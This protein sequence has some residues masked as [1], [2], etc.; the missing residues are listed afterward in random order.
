[1]KKVVA[2]LLLGVVLVTAAL[3]LVASARP[4]RS[5]TQCYNDWET[6]REEALARDASVIQTTL[7]LTLCDVSFGRCIL[8]G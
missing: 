1:V 7:M 5:I 4:P 8:Y 2:L 3:V 6:C